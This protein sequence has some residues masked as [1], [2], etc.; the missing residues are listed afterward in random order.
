MDKRNQIGCEDTTKLSKE[1]VAFDVRVVKSDQSTTISGGE[2]APNSVAGVGLEG[3][4]A[5]IVKGK[6]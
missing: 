3:L 4:C 2:Y 1:G 5:P 6:E